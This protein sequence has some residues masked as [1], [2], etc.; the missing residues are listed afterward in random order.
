MLIIGSKPALS[1]SV[2]VVSVIFASITAV[3]TQLTEAAAGGDTQVGVSSI[4]LV[5]ITVATVNFSMCS[6]SRTIFK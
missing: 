2:V 1:M 5:C 6:A 3:F 4:F